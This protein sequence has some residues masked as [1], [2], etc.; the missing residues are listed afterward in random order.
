M[1]CPSSPSS[2]D[3]GGIFPFIS[4]LA[5]ECREEETECLGGHSEKMWETG[6]LHL[7]R[8]WIFCLLDKET[9][10]GGWPEVASENIR[11]CSSCQVPILHSI[12]QGT[13]SWKAR[14][15]KNPAVQNQGEKSRVIYPWDR[16]GMSYCWKPCKGMSVLAVWGNSMVLHISYGPLVFMCF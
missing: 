3:W 15:S 11:V 5:D 4:Y 12:L 1:Y 10:H 9:L 13:P 16:Q 8:F 6:K 2:W 7:G 14:R